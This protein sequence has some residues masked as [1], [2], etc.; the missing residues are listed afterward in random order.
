MYCTRVVFVENRM[1][2]VVVLKHIR[3]GGAKICSLSSEF[4]SRKEGWAGIAQ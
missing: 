1:L 4:R 3:T 2:G